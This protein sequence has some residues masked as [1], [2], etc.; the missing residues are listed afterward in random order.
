METLFLTTT[1]PKWTFVKKKQRVSEQESVL[2]TLLP[3]FD[4]EETHP[5]ETFI[6]RGNQ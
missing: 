2:D 6:F 4:E 3:D 1:I 5:S